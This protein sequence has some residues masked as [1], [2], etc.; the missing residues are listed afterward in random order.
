M[1]QNLMVQGSRP[2]RDVFLFE[3][4]LEGVDTHSSTNLNVR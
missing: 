2:N 3:W 4:S 1:V